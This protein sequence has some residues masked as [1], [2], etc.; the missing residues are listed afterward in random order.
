MANWILWSKDTE[1]EM[2][3]SF[4]QVCQ[5]VLQGSIRDEHQEIPENSLVSTPDASVG[6]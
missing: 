2:A 4:W 6:R 5:L 1:V 3:L